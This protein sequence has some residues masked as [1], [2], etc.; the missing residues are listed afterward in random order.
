MERGFRDGHWTR[1]TDDLMTLL[2][3]APVPKAPTEVLQDTSAW[4]GWES[5]REGQD[6]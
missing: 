1:E 4:S 6:S 2:E 3:T 5:G